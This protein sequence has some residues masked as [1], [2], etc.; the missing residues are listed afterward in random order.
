MLCRIVP[1][2]VPRDSGGVT[3]INTDP[4]DLAAEALFHRLRVV[5]TMISHVDSRFLRLVRCYEF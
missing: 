2:F 3:T 4:E 5:L 1:E